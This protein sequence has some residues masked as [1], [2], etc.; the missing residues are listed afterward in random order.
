MEIHFNCRINVRKEYQ[1][2]YRN[3]FVSVLFQH[4][5]K[6]FSVRLGSY[7][8]WLQRRLVYASACATC[9]FD[10]VSVNSCHAISNYAHMSMHVTH[11]MWSSERACVFPPPRLCVSAHMGSFMSQQQRH[12][13]KVTNHFLKWGT[14]S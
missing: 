11:Y 7:L 4:A 3:A 1:K 9:S 5:H 2:K 13:L 12:S 6:Q 8:L 14:S 10:S